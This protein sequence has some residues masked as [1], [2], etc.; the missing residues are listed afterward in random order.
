MEPEQATTNPAAIAV[1]VEYCLGI[2]WRADCALL[3]ET[4]TRCAVDGRL[5]D[6]PDAPAREEGATA[7]A[8]LFPF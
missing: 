8:L 3:R 7:L 2:F 4:G 5:S 6:V 1:E